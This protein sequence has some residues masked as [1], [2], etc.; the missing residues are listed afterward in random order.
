MTPVT[1]SY[2]TTDASAPD[3]DRLLG[4]EMTEGIDEVL[5][6]SNNKNTPIFITKA[7]A[8][9]SCKRWFVER[10]R[11]LGS[12]Q[13]GIWLADRDNSG[14]VYL[15]ETLRLRSKPSAQGFLRKGS[16]VIVEFGHIHQTLSF[17]TRTTAENTTYFCHHLSGEMHKRRPA[18]VVSAD[19]R[20]VKVVPVTSQQPDGFLANK[21]IFELESASTQY[22]EEFNR[23]KGS[24]VLC[25]MIQTVS[26]TRILP[27]M[28]RDIRTS[29]RSFR[30]DDSYHR[31]LSPNDL[32]ALEEGLLTAVGM[33]VLKKRNQELLTEN[34][35][36]RQAVKALQ[37]R[38]EE[39]TALLAASEDAERALRGELSLMSEKQRILC[40]LYMGASPHSTVKAVEE[41][42]AE[43]LQLDDPG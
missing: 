30:R 12:D 19:R 11:D 28:A 43:Y 21:S 37:D 33:S 25:E 16:L 20:G 27:P 17:G 39:L 35:T 6:P 5:V 32:R 18:I 10:V 36:A 1:I 31:K 8:G 29:T 38:Q 26:P 7:F 22:V 41:E 4:R 3:K 42:V 34:D 23:G 15:S 9:V 24:Y 13:W 2:Y 14:E 40:E